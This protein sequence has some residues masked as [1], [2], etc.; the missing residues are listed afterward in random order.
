MRLS[1]VVIV[2]LGVGIGWLWWSQQSNTDPPAWQGYVETDYVKAAPVQQGLLTAI[3]VSPG[4][5]VA[6]GAP[7]FTQDDTAERAARDQAAR[8]L[9]QAEHQLANLEAASK[10][11]EVTQAEAIGDYALWFARK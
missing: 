6:K 2:V 11:T 5:E 7:L 4:A 8:Q 1:V 3:S 9:G 10:P